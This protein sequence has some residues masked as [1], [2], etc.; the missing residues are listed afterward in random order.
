[1]SGKVLIIDDDRDLCH[2][3]QIELQNHG[4]Q[5]DSAESGELGLEKARKLKY[6]LIVLDVGL[7]DRGGFEVC[8]ELRAGGDEV[9][10]LIL[11]ARSSLLD[12]VVGLE[13]GADD[14]LEKPFHVR[15]LVAR[16]QALLRRSRKT[17]R[18]S[19]TS[20]TLLTFGTLSIDRARMRVMRG[21]TLVQL[22]STE[23]KL[24]ETLALSPGV[25]FSREQLR[26]LVWGYTAS[27]F[28]HT[29]TTT[30]HRLRSKLEPIPSQPTYIFAVRGVG[31]RFVERSELEEGAMR[32]A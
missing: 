25:V 7:P 17:S 13:I 20:D 30:F 11:S 4:F 8:R 32:A 14:Y 10:V 9:P 16:L 6:D 31:Y 27:S 3:L 26:Q 5:V 23:F 29:I 2:S 18:E 28:D 15:E 1:M 22:S 12:K 19:Q 21:D 24:L